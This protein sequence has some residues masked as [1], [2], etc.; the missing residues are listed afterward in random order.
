MFFSEI[1]EGDSRFDAGSGGQKL[2]AWAAARSWS[3]ARYVGYEVKVSRR[4][5]VQDN[6]WQGYLPSCTEFWFVTAPGVCSPEEIGDQCGLLVATK[7]CRRFL[8][9]KKAPDLRGQFSYERAFNMLKT[10]LMRQW[11]DPRAGIANSQTPAQILELLR[12]D[13]EDK[14]TGWQ[15]GYELARRRRALDRREAQL[16]G[17]EEKVQEATQALNR[18]GLRINHSW[19]PVEDQLRRIVREKGRVSESLRGRMRKLAGE[20]EA[21]EKHLAEF[22][23]SEADQESLLDGLA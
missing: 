21:L 11:Q 16:K 12:Q 14:L 17:Q 3:K 22:Q 2:D 18:M 9:K 5:F 15:I 1:G 13:S 7:T 8:I 23:V 10:A 20:L 6:K 4:D 19:D